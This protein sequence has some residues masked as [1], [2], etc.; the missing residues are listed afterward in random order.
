MSDEQEMLEFNPQQPMQEIDVEPEQETLVV[1]EEPLTAKQK[2]GRGRWL[3]LGVGLLIAAILAESVLQIYQAW[4]SHW[5]LGAL[6][7]AAI[8]ILVVVS[9]Y[10]VIRECVLLYRLKHRRQLKRHDECTSD[11]AQ[12]LV[13][14]LQRTDLLRE[15]QRIDE[16]YWQPQERAE[17]LQQDIMQNVDRDAQRV[18]NKSASET[19]VLVAVSGNSLLDAVIMLWR[20]Q[21]MISKVAALYGVELGYFSR[22][23]LWR[24]ILTNIAYAGVSELLMDAGSQLLSAELAAKLS[25]RAGQGLGAGLLTARLGYAARQLCRPLPV[26]KERR[27]RLTDVQTSLLCALKNALPQVWRA[28]SNADNSGK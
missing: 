27:A 12:A 22:I 13:K 6:W 15:W 4:Q 24:M 28:R 18:I 17:R 21:R 20:N 1:A 9:G 2:S 7:L 14:Q 11:Y 10:W 3:I 16:D 19:A 25:M 5:W 23:R 26:P 8:V